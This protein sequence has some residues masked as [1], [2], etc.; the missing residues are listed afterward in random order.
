MENNKTEFKVKGKEL[1]PKII[2]LMRE[3]N[4]ERFII[5]DNDGH[6]YMEI[7]LTKSDSSETLMALLAK[8]SVLAEL[9]SDFTI[10]VIKKDSKNKKKS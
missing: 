2:E 4:V 10:E 8:A 9:I 3:G 5:K 1:L 6:I 7:P